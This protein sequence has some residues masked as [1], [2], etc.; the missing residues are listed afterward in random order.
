MFFGIDIFPVGA[1]WFGSPIIGS[2]FDLLIFC[3]G[4][5]FVNDFVQYRRRQRAEAATRILIQ[6]RSCVDYIN[7]INL[8]KALYQ[9]EGYYP[10]KI[11]EVG[12]QSE[13]KSFPERPSRLIANRIFEFKRSVDES[14][15]QLAGMEARKL[16]ALSSDF[17]EKVNSLS[18]SV[19][20]QLSGSSDLSNKSELLT[21]EYCNEIMDLKKEFEKILDPIIDGRYRF[22]F[23]NWSLTQI[24]IVLVLILLAA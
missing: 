19:G 13:V 2:L 21:Q 8:R 20:G 5:F 1:A 14:I 4:V 23:W 18:N 7:E 10:N 11:P 15:T 12:S 9:Y 17:Q 24:F 3:I 22:F 6:V 16:I